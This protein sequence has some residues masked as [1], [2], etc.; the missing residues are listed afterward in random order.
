M[1]NPLKVKGTKDRV[2]TIY[3]TYDWLDNV[4]IH[5]SVNT[6]K[7]GFNV[8]EDLY[9]HDPRIYAPSFVKLTHEQLVHEYTKAGKE[10]ERRIETQKQLREVEVKD[11]APTWNTIKNRFFI[12]AAI[13]FSAWGITSCVDHMQE[14]RKM[15][16]QFVRVELDRYILVH[17]DPP[18]HMYVTL[19]N[20]DTG[21]VTQRL[22]VGKHC[23]AWRSNTIGAEYNIA[24]QVMFDPKTKREYEVFPS[25]SGV[26]C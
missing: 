14:A 1:R 26:F 11:A 6:K 19:K 20:V 8:R 17:I 18:K 9:L 24:M 2:Y 23:N 16:P 25:L 22:H 10:Y 13:L 4:R 21:A 7:F 12:G 5:V 3:W 15:Q